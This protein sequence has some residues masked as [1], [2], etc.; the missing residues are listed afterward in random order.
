MGAAQERVHSS[1]H[2]VQA[3][4]NITPHHHQRDRPPAAL[5]ARHSKSLD[6]LKITGTGH[7]ATL[8]TR[9]SV[10]EHDNRKKKDGE[11][12][13]NGCVD[14]TLPRQHHNFSGR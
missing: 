10:K 7:F 13:R 6:Q 2:T 9:G 14:V 4:L 12:E 3:S 11:L 1:G 5:P 8:P